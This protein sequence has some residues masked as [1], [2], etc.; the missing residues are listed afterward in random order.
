MYMKEDWST[1]NSHT[2]GKCFNGSG[3]QLAVAIKKTIK[4][5]ESITVW[6]VCN[7]ITARFSYSIMLANLKAGVSPWYSK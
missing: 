7:L 4:T 5:N 1:K 6:Q 3:I 2:Y